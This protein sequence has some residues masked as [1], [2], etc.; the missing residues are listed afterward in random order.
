MVIIPSFKGSAVWAVV[1]AKAPT[2]SNV[3]GIHHGYDLNL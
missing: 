1:Y 2:I 3:I